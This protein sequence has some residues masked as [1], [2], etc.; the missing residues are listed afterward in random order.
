MQRALAEFHVSG[1]R[2]STT[3]QFL[4]NV[5]DNPK[6]RAAEHSTSLVEEMLRVAHR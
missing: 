2:L 3:K 1:P 4:A 6:F 5:L